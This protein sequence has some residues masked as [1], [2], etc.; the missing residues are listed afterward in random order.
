MTTL[1]D[2]VGVHDAEVRH[3]RFKFGVRVRRTLDYVMDPP[4][5]DSTAYDLI[6]HTKNDLS[7][8][9]I[10]GR[11]NAF[12]KQGLV[13]RHE[14]IKDKNP[15]TNVLISCYSL[16]PDYLELLTDEDGNLAAHWGQA[17]GLD[18]PTN[19]SES[20]NPLGVEIPE[21]AASEPEPD[22]HFVSF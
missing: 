11:L 16:H 22:T 7:R 19:I 17:D 4:G 3:Q 14:A 10:Q 9:A 20:Y 1:P 18:V 21:T 5:K 15:E 12:K 13:V 2:V 6:G 8:S